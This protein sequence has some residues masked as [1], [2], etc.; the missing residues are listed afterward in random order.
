MEIEKIKLLIEKN[1]TQRSIAEELG[2]SQTTIRYWLK[3]LKL[4]TTTKSIDKSLIAQG[5]KKCNKC[6]VEKSVDDFYKRTDTEGYASQCKDCST[7]YYGNRIRNVKIRMIEYKG[8]ECERCKLKLKDTHYSVFDFHH[9]NPEEKDLR[10]NRIKYQ[11]W[12]VIKNEI[13]KCSLVCANCHRIIHSEL[14]GNNHLIYK[15]FF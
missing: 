9:I 14:G 6:S 3:K 11:K 5:L 1:Y 8:G 4:K 13:D 10:F 12:E 15:R 2:L 7:L